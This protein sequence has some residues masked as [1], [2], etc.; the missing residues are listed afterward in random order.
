MHIS[1]FIDYN[2]VNSNNDN[3]NADTD[4]YPNANTYAK[5]IDNANRNHSSTFNYRLISQ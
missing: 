2:S 4:T 3:G 5:S 1:T